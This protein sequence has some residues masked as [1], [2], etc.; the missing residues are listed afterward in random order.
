MS[1]SIFGERLP[2]TKAAQSP[3]FSFDALNPLRQWLDGLEVKNRRL[4]RLLY[5]VIPGQCPFERD[6][7]LFGRK[8]AHIPPL[9]KLNPLYDQLVSLRFR[10]L[11]YLVDVCGE[12]IQ[13]N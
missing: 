7:I 5:K 8:L 1:D 3:S 9:C 10:S 2:A 12:T 11:C 13:C 4:A 6:V